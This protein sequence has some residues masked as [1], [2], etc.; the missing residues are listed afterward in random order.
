MAEIEFVLVA[1]GCGGG[2][3]SYFHVKPNLCYGR[4]SCGWFGVVIKK[5]GLIPIR[6]T[7]QWLLK[8]SP[9]LLRELT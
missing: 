2:V 8:Q 9:M 6:G 1:G 4:L 3:Q 7:L 5:T